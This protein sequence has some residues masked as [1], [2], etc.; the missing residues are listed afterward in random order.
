[1]TLTFDEID[2]LL[3]EHQLPES[4][5][6]YRA[7]WANDSV[8]HAHSQQWLE[9]G[10]RVANITMTEARVTFARITDN[11][12]ALLQFFNTL[13]MELEQRAPGVFH[14]ASSG[15]LYFLTLDVVRA[16]G[17]RVGS[18][19]CS[20]TRT[21][22]IR[23]ELFIDTYSQETSK[24]LFGTLV[25][26]KEAI[27]DEVGDRLSWEPM[28]ENR[29]S[30]IARYYPGT[31]T[32][33]AGPLA[34]LRARIVEAAMRFVPVLRCELVEAIPSVLGVQVNQLPAERIS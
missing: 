22:R 23:I 25:E 3:G 9:A 34:N 2:A 11:Q 7:W 16:G 8:S 20:F 29:G 26:R 6:K 14:L 28:V 12:Q 5:R 4:A 31:I 1:M 32:D 30:R 10:W 15:G 33:T 17:K 19:Y 27:E 21:R 13:Q 18:F 24:Q